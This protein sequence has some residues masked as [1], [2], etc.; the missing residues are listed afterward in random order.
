MDVAEDT[1]WPTRCRPD[2]KTRG[3]IYPPGAGM[4]IVQ[5]LSGRRGRLWHQRTGTSV[6]P[7]AEVQD[8]YIWSAAVGLI[9]ENLPKI[10]RNFLRVS[11]VAW[12]NTML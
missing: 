7:L 3:R 10:G 4:S 6:N 8:G 11:V 9:F 1:G 5:G 2:R 12:Y